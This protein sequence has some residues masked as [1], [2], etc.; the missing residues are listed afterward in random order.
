VPAVAYVVKVL[1]ADDIN[2]LASPLN[3][4]GQDTLCFIDIFRLAP[5]AFAGQSHRAEAKGIYFKIAA[6]F[7]FL[8]WLVQAANEV[9]RTC[10]RS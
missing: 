4:A 3:F 7:K 2:H 9:Q 6:N 10:F 5:D 8:C 1:N